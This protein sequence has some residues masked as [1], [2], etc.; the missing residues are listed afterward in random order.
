MLTSSAASPARH[1]VRRWRP[2][3]DLTTGQAVGAGQHV[4]SRTAAA[5][6]IGHDYLQR[7]RCVRVAWPGTRTCST[8]SPGR[9]GAGG[10]EFGAGPPRRA[11]SGQ[12]GAAEPCAVAGDGL[13]HRPDRGRGGRGRADVRRP[14]PAVR[15]DARAVGPLAGSAAGCAAGRVRVARGAGPGSV[16]AGSRGRHATVR[17]G[18]RAAVGVPGRRRA[19]AGRPTR[20]PIPIAARGIAPARQAGRTRPL[21][22]S[23]SGRPVG[24][25]AAAAS[26][27]RPRFWTGP[28]S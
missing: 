4:A 27:R 17:G 7:P 5:P 20:T 1:A 25:G 23:W 19:V 18:D 6:T 28:P 9:R 15:A 13:S 21:P 10:S 16:S 12:D 26:R 24:R 22:Q 14:A 8:G 11:R 3:R 2:R